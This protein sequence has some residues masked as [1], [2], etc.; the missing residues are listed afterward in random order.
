MQLEVGLEEQRAFSWECKKPLHRMLA[1]SLLFTLEGKQCCL[2]RPDAGLR[3]R[4]LASFSLR[5][6]STFSCSEENQPE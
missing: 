5:S 3:Q 6:T 2:R 1:E 4:V